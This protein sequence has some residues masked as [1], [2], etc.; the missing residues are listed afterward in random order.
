MESPIERR[1]RARPVA[2]APVD[3]LLARADELARRWVLALIVARPLQE[4]A[5]VPIEDL[6]REAPELCARLLRALDSDAELE[7]LRG[8]ESAGRGDAAPVHRLGPPAGARDDGTA[9]EEV[10]ALRGVLWE[11]LLEEL[12]W[13]I[14]DRSSARLV[15]DLSDRLAYVCATA[16]AAMLA[17]PAATPA[18][19]PHPPAPGRGRVVFGAARDAEGRRGAILVDE[20]EEPGAPAGTASPPVR[21]AGGARSASGEDRAGRRAERLGGSTDRAAPAKRPATA[22]RPLPWD[23]PLRSERSQGRSSN[24]EDSTAPRGAVGR[25]DPVLRITRRSVEQVDE[26]T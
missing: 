5:A 25:E 4:M 23:I 14:S 15:A 2:D 17:Q 18:E 10:E 11:A 20:F 16:L 22:G 6:A 1:P 12:R 3:A 8:P 21:E 13:P 24:P 19:D 9:V 26:R 7:R